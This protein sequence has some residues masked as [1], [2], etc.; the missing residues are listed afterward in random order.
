MLQ[1]RCSAFD[2]AHGV[3]DGGNMVGMMVVGSKRGDGLHG[4]VSCT[5][6]QE[7]KGCHGVVQVVV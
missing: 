1:E 5:V 4:D 7:F 6:H 2:C 3:I